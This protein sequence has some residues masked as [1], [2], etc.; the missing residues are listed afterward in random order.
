[1]FLLLAQYD[2]RSVIPLDIVCRDFF[3]HL[4]LPKFAW[5]LNEGK[6]RL[7][8]M[9]MDASAKTAKGVH[10]DDLA[11]YLDETRAAALEEVAQL[12]S[13]GATA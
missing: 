1:M 13:A 3:F 9:R 12:S 2:G 5:H 6:I 10:V 7:P 4:S 11:A 8:V